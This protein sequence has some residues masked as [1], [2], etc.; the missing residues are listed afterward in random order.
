M[1]ADRGEGELLLFPS[2]VCDLERAARLSD[3]AVIAGDF[4]NIKLELGR[5]VS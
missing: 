2:E 5:V 3:A 1:I 4:K